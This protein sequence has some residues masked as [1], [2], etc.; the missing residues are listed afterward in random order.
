[1]TTFTLKARLRDDGQM[2]LSV[3]DGR[4]MTRDAA[5][6]DPRRCDPVTVARAVLNGLPADADLQIDAPAGMTPARNNMH[7]LRVIGL[8]NSAKAHL[9]SLPEN[10]L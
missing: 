5:A 9:D 7:F 6:F 10:F 4:G 8:I 3:S 1:M 2:L